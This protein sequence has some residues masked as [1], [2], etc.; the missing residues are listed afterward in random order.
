[1]PIVEGDLNWRYSGGAGN[2]DPNASL[3]GVISTTEVPDATLENMFANVDSAE[4]T[5][6]SI[7]YRCRYIQNNHGSITWQTVVTWIASQTTSTD[8]SYDI[9]LDPAGVNGTATTIAN[10]DTAPAG[11]T[12]SAPANKGSGLAI[13]DIPAGQHMAI[14]V[15]RTVNAGAAA[16]NNDA[17]V[18]Q[19]EG[20]TTA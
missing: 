18:N 14:W 15:R 9:G 11:V 2:S 7:K 8:T 5:A 3:G 20:D 12:F 4:A 17:T 13:G 19:V 16:F 1:M 6:G 10:E